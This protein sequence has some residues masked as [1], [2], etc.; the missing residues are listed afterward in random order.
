M[1]KI[2]LLC[3]QCGTPIELSPARY[4]LIHEL[5]KRNYQIHVFFP[6][7][8][9]NRNIRSE[10]HRAINVRDLSIKKIKNEIRSIEPEYVIAFTYEDVLVLYD[11]P[12]KMKKTSF[13]YFNLE[14][15]TPSTEKYVQPKGEFFNIRCGTAYV[16][17][18]IKEMIFIRQSKMFVIQDALR[19][20]VSAKYGISHPNTLLIPN[21][22]TFKE[23]DV[24][25]SQYSGM[26]YS[27]GVNR[28]Q[29]ESLVEGL[30]SMPDLP[31]TFSGWS[32]D[33][34][35]KQYKKLITTHP[36]IKLCDQKIPPERF[37]EYLKQYAIGLVWYSRT[38]DENVNNIGMASGKLFRH[39]SLGQPVI[40]NNCPG[41]GK[42]IAKYKLGIV[43][44]GVSELQGAYEHLM[45][46]YS[47]YQNNILNVYKNK[48]DFS[49]RVQPFFEQL[50]RL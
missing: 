47:Y 6:G 26:I 48:F 45:E 1:R 33:W 38:R 42:M 18:K 23:E 50:E 4:Q 22:Y 10:I 29:L 43:I 36:S 40:V 30:S 16:R 2:I 32:D 20:K 31:I 24:V 14:I 15:Y 27:G 12:C 11:L 3:L 13:V 44:H 25:E 17:N 49:K 9:L 19:K 39:L 8:I 28:L 34:F 37:S 7:T 41:I 5:N 21:S 35:R 46:N